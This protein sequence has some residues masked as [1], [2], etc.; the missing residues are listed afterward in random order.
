MGTRLGG[1]SEISFLMGARQRGEQ[2]R[3][4]FS[5]WVAIAKGARKLPSSMGE[6][7][8]AGERRNAPARTAAFGLHGHG[9]AKRGE[10]AGSPDG[11]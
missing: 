3:S 9:E 6:P 2:E 7:A 8:P 4:P 1:E 10:R 11:A 5:R